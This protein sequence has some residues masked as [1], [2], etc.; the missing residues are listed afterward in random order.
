VKELLEDLLDPN[1][2]ERLGC[3]SNVGGN[4]TEDI[5]SHAFY[6]G[7]NFV[8]LGDC[9]LEA[10]YR[11]ECEAL[12]ATFLKHAA[13]KTAFDTP[14][15]VGDNRWCDDWDY[16]CTVGATV[17]TAQQG[18][19]SFKQARP[20][21]NVGEPVSETNSSKVEPNSSN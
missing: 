8:A 7:L 21:S 13:T 17:E 20:G 16:T 6:E 3:R 5:E 9:S 11:K 15:Y 19:T 12:A 10:P 4:V 2:D 18:D 14:P 1:P